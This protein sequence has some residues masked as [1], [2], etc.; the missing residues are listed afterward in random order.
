MSLLYIL[1]DKLMGAIVCTNSIDRCGG[2]ILLDTLWI[3]YNEIIGIS[4]NALVTMRWG[5]LYYRVFYVAVIFAWAMSNTN[6]VQRAGNFSTVSV[7]PI[8]KSLVKLAMK[9]SLLYYI[10]ILFSLTAV[11]ISY[12]KSFLLTLRSRQVYQFLATWLLAWLLD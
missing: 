1:C 11:Q 12:H 10:F 3:H 4:H 5:L 9:I 7:K 2:N 6:L 8:P